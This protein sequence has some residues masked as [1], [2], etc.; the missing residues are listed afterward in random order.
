M[1]QFLI[2][3]ME[4]FKS[5]PGVRIFWAL[6][7][8]WDNGFTS[9][10]DCCSQLD[11]RKHALC[12]SL[13][14]WFWVA[15]GL[16][17]WKFSH[18]VQIAVLVLGSSMFYGKGLDLPSHNRVTPSHNES[19]PFSWAL[20]LQI[21][22]CLLTSQGGKA[23]VA[24]RVIPRLSPSTLPPPSACQ[25]GRSVR[26]GGF[27]SCPLTEFTLSYLDSLNLHDAAAVWS[28]ST[29]NLTI[30]VSDFNSSMSAGPFMRDVVEY[31]ALKIRKHLR[32]G[33]VKKTEQA[34][35]PPLVAQCQ[36]ST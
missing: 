3:K 21:S 1:V 9:D 5:V 4:F 7:V 32:G 25:S 34:N 19:Q 15:A 31:T 13:A 27:S 11:P 18:F 24:Q 36:H 23:S 6:W 28:D 22:P 12:K 2:S 14:C 30:C 17:F 16:V 26:A 10:C 20:I 29:C 33:K 8:H 35:W